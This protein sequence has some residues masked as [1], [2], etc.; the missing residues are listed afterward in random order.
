MIIKEYGNENKETIMLLYG[1]GLSWWN[2]K[3]EIEYL[4]NN[5][6]IIIPILDGHS[7]SDAE[8]ISIE[9]NASRIIEYIDEHCSGH[10]LMM[11][12]LSLG[13][14]ILIEIL[15]QK[16]DICDYAIIE[17]AL[18]IPMKV[19]NKMVDFSFSMFYGLISKKWFSKLQ[20][21]S[22]KIRKDLFN[23]YYQ[24]SCN[25]KKESLI[26]FMK[27]N[28]KYDIKSTLKNTSAK[29]LILVGGKERAIMKASARKTQE[30]IKGSKLEILDGY[31]HGELSIN[32]PEQ[33][34]EKLENLIFTTSILG[35]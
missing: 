8:F 11:G 31:Y 32:H 25:I 26:A 1:G 2:Y 29:V 7:G 23:E 24:D 22:L 34:V 21:D 14:Q 16:S 12:G 27:A 20:F 33:Y 19:T 15:S 10:I 17:S 13:G 35:E 28:T 18:T 6:H 4:K 3:Y 9:E 30:I 5:F